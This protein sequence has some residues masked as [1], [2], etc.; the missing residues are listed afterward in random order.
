METLTY[1]CEVISPMFLTGADGDTPELRPSSLKGAMRFWWRAL[2]GHL[3]LTDRTEKRR[4]ETIFIRTGLK[5]RETQ[6]F[7]GAGGGQDAQRSSFSIQ[8]RA[9]E[10]DIQSEALVPHKRFMKAKAF[11]TGSA[12][13]VIFR[14]PKGY[15]ISA[16]E[17]EK[18]IIFDQE[19]LDALFRLTCILGE[20]GKRVRRGMG[21]VSVESI[22][23]PTLFKYIS[24]MTPFYKRE[25][26]LIVN[27]FKG[28][29]EDYGVIEE[30]EIGT[31]TEVAPFLLKVSE[32]T[33]HGKAKHKESYEVS[34]RHAIP[35]DIWKSCR[36]FILLR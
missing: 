17:N 12:F 25:D 22:S 18:E 24:V 16:K 20:L 4:D 3:P 9:T 6:I 2:N 28:R 31:P 32:A 27:I 10:V 30:I 36:N 14:F 23:M 5:T 33:H 26:N 13:E 8:I 15:K 7:G 11:T 29:I 1:T 35:L 19:K 34:M 21:S